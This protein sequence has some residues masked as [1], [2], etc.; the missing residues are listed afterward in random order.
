MQDFFI[1]FLLKEKFKAN[2]KCAY[3]FMLEKKYF[4]FWDSH[5][6]WKK[7][8]YSLQI[9]FMPECTILCPTDIR[10]YRRII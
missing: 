8:E 10:E 4:V 6:F 9:C 5:A 2:L 3:I 7:E 1:F